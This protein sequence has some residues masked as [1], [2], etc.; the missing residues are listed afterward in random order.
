M[1]Y[2][3]KDTLEIAVMKLEKD[4][5]DR[6]EDVGAAATL[7][8][9]VLILTYDVGGDFLPVEINVSKDPDVQ[10]RVQTSVPV[11]RYRTQVYTRRKKPT[12]E[13]TEASPSQG[14]AEGS[15]QRALDGSVGSV[16]RPEGAKTTDD[17]SEV[18]IGKL[19]AVYTDIPGEPESVLPFQESESDLRQS[20]LD[21]H[22]EATQSSGSYVTS[23]QLVGEWFD[24]ESSCIISQG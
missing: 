15:S 16:G 3:T 4:W 9:A 14:A 8:S 2:R 5:L 7:G 20:L 12:P 22:G 17:N 18:S 13:Q 24:C 23:V 10:T 19:C 6:E 21:R 11:R 1:P